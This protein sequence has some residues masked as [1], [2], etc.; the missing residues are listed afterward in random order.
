MSACSETLSLLDRHPTKDLLARI[1]LP[2]IRIRALLRQP[3]ALPASVVHA[4]ETQERRAALASVLCELDAVPKGKWRGVSLPSHI[5]RAMY[6]DYLRTQSITATG[7]LF[8]RK[9]KTVRKLFR[10]H[11]FKLRKRTRPTILYRGVRYHQTTDGRYYRAC[12]TINHHQVVTLLHQRV[13]EDEHGPIP[14]GYRVTFRDGNSGNV[15]PDNLICL[16]RSKVARLIRQRNATHA[17]VT[18]VHAA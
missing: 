5:V 17:L 16:P 14:A 4:D 8:N 6:A 13:Y 2:A 18:S 15:K 10:G 1:A 3:D 11:G 9:A 12:A 7:K